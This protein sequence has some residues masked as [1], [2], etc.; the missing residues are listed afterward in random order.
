VSHR[1]RS[2]IAL[3]VLALVA[4]CDV[5]GRSHA[6]PPPP[7]PKPCDFGPHYQCQPINNDAALQRLTNDSGSDQTP[8][9][10]RTRLGTELCAISLVLTGVELPPAANPLV[11]RIRRIEEL[12]PGS[13]I[14][15][16]TVACPVVVRGA[17]TATEPTVTVGCAFTDG[18]QCQPVNNDAALQRIATRMDSAPKDKLAVL[19]EEGCA[20]DRV[21]AGVWAPPDATPLAKR[22]SALAAQYGAMAGPGAPGLA[23]AESARCPGAHPGG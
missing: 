20:I 11:Q 18:S 17:P 8:A 16:A 15:P 22:W 7:L 23:Q 9:V 1:V 10:V 21:A 2:S 3:V 5:L 13:A 12:I 19:T 6:L 14:D 4:G